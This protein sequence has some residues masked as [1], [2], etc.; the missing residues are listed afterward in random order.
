MAFFD[1]VTWPPFIL[2][3]GLVLKNIVTWPP[4]ILLHGLFSNCYMASFYIVTWSPF[5]IVT[6]PLCNKY[7]YMASFYIVTWPLFL[8]IFIKWPLLENIV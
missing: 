8:D 5:Y 4:F 6:W 3:H 2:L 1:V 7:C